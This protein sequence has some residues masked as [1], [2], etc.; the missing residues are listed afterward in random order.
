MQNHSRTTQ[1]HQ[2]VNIKWDIFHQ[3][4]SLICYLL[5]ERELLHLESDFMHL[6]VIELKWCAVQINLCLCDPILLDMGSKKKNITLSEGLAH[7][8]VHHHLRQL[9]VYLQSGAL[10]FISELAGVILLFINKEYAHIKFHRYIYGPV[11][12]LLLR[13]HT[14]KL[15][16]LS[17]QIYIRSHKRTSEKSH[18]W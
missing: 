3:H 15:W 17:S 2:E 8:T 6:N 12:Q 10:I 9:S 18:D 4:K 7:S 1:H 16:L 14:L 11:S 5:M 13:V